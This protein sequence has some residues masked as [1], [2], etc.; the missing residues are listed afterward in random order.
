MNEDEL[1]QIIVAELVRFPMH[2]QGSGD[3]IPNAKRG[4]QK[5]AILAVVEFSAIASNG[6]GQTRCSQLTTAG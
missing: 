2:R 6:C 4:T 5:T 3:P 1:T